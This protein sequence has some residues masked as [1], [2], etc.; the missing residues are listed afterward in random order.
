MIPS[1]GLYSLALLL[2]KASAPPR[3]IEGC[4]LH[5]GWPFK[6]TQNHDPSH[7]LHVIDLHSVV[8][9]AGEW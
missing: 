3:V 6:V 5:P 7:G 2:L 1:L 8:G 9:Y 4:C